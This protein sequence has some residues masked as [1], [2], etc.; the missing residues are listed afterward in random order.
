[1]TTPQLTLISFGSA[2]ALTRQDIVGDY[3]EDTFQPRQA[4]M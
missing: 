2:K 3:L 4:P 1:M